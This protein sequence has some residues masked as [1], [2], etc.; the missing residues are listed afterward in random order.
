M[1]RS[2][3][4]GSPTPFVMKFVEGTFREFVDAAREAGWCVEKAFLGAS[5]RR[6]KWTINKS[7]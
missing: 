4:G 1:L 6:C 2:E 5:E 7:S 3:S